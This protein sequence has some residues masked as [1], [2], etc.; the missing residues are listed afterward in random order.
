MKTIYT[1]GYEGVA[2][3]DFIRTLKDTG[4]SLLLDVRELPQSRRPGFSKRAL[5]E[6]LADAE[7]GYRH[8]RQLGDPKLGRDAAR[9]GAM[10]EFRSIFNAHLDLEASQKALKE[11]A[12]EADSETVV[13]MCY[14]RAPHECHRSLVAQRLVS[15]SSFKIVHLGVQAGRAVRGGKGDATARR[16]AGAR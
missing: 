7:I 13:L 16:L 11:V 5:S 15:L 6:A 1:L 9:R 14:E 3:A 2:L 10:E 12:Q 8:V 4:V